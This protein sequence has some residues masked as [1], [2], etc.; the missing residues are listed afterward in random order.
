MECGEGRA[1]GR[2]IRVCVKGTICGKGHQWSGAV[3]ME[4]GRLVE[5]PFFIDSGIFMEKEN[6]RVLAGSYTDE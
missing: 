1:C 3:A 4:E 2:N 6:V 5:R